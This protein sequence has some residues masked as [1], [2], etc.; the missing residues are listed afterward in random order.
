MKLF[1]IWIISCRINYFF[2]GKFVKMLSYSWI[3]F[4]F[5]YF[6]GYII[7][8]SLKLENQSLWLQNNIMLYIRIFYIPINSIWFE[9]FTE[10]PHFRSLLDTIHSIFLME[11]GILSFP[12]ADYYI[13][14]FFSPNNH[15]QLLNQ[16]LSLQIK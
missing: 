1:F 7:N 11:I 16:L 8:Y 9:N 2:F 6:V 4:Q 15:L 14:T 13:G 5:A 12:S 10:N 3:S